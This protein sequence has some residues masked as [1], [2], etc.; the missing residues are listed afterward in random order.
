M[1]PVYVNAGSTRWP[2]LVKSWD[3]SVVHGFEMPA[4]GTG[5]HV[6]VLGGST[7][8]F[9]GKRGTHIASGL[10][11]AEY[12]DDIGGIAWVRCDGAV[13]ELS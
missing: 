2:M 1:S 6:L 3:G 13:T 5:D 10:D 7:F 11:S 12:T 9:T 8:C 4:P